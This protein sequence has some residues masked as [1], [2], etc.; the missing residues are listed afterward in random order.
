MRPGERIGI[1]PSIDDMLDTDEIRFVE[2]I[3]NDCSGFGSG[4]LGRRLVVL[5]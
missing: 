2:V 1:K 4:A 3:D 5:T